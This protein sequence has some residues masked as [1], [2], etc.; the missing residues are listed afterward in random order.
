MVCQVKPT[1]LTFPEGQ[2]KLPNPLIGGFLH[3]R[4]ECAA[5]PAWRMFRVCGLGFTN[6]LP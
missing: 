3:T 4:R 5:N 6:T 1:A 2:G